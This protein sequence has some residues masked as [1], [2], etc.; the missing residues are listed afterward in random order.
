MEGMCS[1]ESGMESSRMF[2]Q[3][4]L[5]GTDVGAGKTTQHYR[6]GYVTP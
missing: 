3:F 6:F 5:A 4:T 1:K 2:I